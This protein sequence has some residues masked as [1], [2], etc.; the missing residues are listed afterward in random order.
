[1]TFEQAFA[2]TKALPWLIAAAFGLALAAM[3]HFY[4]GKRDELATT[5]ANFDS[6]VATTKEL[7][8]KAAADN[9]R[10]DAEHKQNLKTIREEH[11]SEIPRIRNEAVANYLSGRPAAVVWQQSAANPSGSSMRGNRAG[12]GLDDG[13]KRQ[14]VPDEAFIQN[15]AEDAAKLDAWQQYCTL[16]HCPV[17]D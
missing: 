7:G 10:K 6:F 12:I 17:I 8:E 5:T 14:C 13:E 15:A 16:N 3:T 11:E 4:L 9:A 1:M 2:A